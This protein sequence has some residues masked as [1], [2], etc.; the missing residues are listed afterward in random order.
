M[1][2]KL[3]I[4]GIGHIIE[5]LASSIVSSHAVGGI[6]SDCEGYYKRPGGGDPSSDEVRGTC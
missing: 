2:I 1:I 6:E 5:E 3:A 4:I